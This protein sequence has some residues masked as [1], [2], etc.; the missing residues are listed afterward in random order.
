MKVDQDV[1]N[2]IGYLKKKGYLAYL[3][4][5]DINVYV[6]TIA[7]KLKVDGFYANST[8]GFDSNGVLE[9]INYRE[10]QDEIK[11]EQLQE[12][13]K[14]LGIDMSQVVFVGNDEN[15]I[16][17]FKVTKQGIVIK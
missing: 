2:L 17:A 6:E 10:N 9:K 5:G 14:K 15:D 7:K 11:V 3:I 16:E 1:I 13:I 4:S 8:L 12:L